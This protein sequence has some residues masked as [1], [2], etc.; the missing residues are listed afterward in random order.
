MTTELIQPEGVQLCGVWMALGM[1][2]RYVYWATAGQYLVNMSVTILPDLVMGVKM[3]QQDAWVTGIDFS[4]WMVGYVVTRA[5]KMNVIE[6]REIGRP[7]LMWIDVRP[8]TKTWRSIGSTEIRSTRQKDRKTWRMKTWCAEP[9]WRALQRRIKY[10]YISVSLLWF[11]FYWQWNINYKH[12]HG[13]LL[14]TNHP[15]IWNL[16]FPKKWMDTI[17]NESE[18]SLTRYSRTPLL[19]PPSKSH[20]GGRKS[21]VVVHEGFDLTLHNMF[22]KHVC[23]CVW[24]VQCINIQLLNVISSAA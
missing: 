17:I 14:V 1:N 7:K 9:K 18:F 11:I 10:K 2:S 6:H 24:N 20:W 22:W 23:V 15:N 5:R 13:I 4:F 16:P 8:Y 12:S 19:R 21:G 3:Y